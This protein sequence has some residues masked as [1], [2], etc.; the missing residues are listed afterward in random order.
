MELVRNAR[1]L[2]T[3]INTGGA[4]GK[5]IEIPQAIGCY[6]RDNAYACRVYCRHAANHQ[7]FDARQRDI[8]DR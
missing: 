2:R 1:A 5:K 6:Y 4:Y 7:P 3:S 8:L